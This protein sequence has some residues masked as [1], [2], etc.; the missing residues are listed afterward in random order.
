MK[1]KFNKKLDYQLDAIASVVNVFEGQRMAQD[2]FTVVTPSQQLPFHEI[3]HGDLGIG[4]RLTLLPEGINENLKKIQ[5]ENLLPATAPL[6]FSHE[7]AYFN[8]NIGP[9]LSSPRKSCII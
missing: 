7:T 1:L 4:N 3:A 9:L 8:K 5:L 6:P 2:N